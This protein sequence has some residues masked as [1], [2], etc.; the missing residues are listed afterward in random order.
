MRTHV[1]AREMIEEVERDLLG[2]YDLGN[3]GCV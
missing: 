1:N 2:G 3:K